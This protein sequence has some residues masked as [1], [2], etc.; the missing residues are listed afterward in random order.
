MSIARATGSVFALLIAASV[1]GAQPAKPAAKAAHDST[2]HAA[3][4]TA[5]AAASAASAKGAAMAKPAAAAKDSG[6]A[7]HAAKKH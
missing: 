2:K 1:A 5:P 4:A 3:T 7:T 6:K